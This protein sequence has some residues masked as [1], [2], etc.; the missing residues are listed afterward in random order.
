MTNNDDFDVS[1][2]DPAIRARALIDRG[3]A[4]AEA[5]ERIAAV[6]SLKEAEKVAADAG[7]TS[8]AI[9][10]HINRGWALWY[11]GETGGAI[12]LYSEGA[13][14]AREASDI[15]HLRVALSN[16]GVA[17]ST[18]GR[19]AEAVAVYEEYLPYV[20][21]DAAES[22]DAHLNTGSALVGLGRPDEAIAH[23]E[24][25]ER[26]ATAANLREPLVIVHLNRGVLLERS[27]DT[28]GAFDLYWK[29]FDIAEEAKDADLV[30]RVTMTLGRAY[31]R[32]GD[33]THA[34]DCFGEAANAFR[35]LEDSVRLADALHRHGLA[36]RRVG[37][38]DAA[39]EAW[40]EE[41]PILRERGDELALGECI[42]L[43]AQVLGALTPSP[44]T[45][46]TFSEAASHY[47]SAKAIDRLAE[48]Y[49]AH[50]QWLRDRRMDDEAASRLKKAF[51]ALEAVPNPTVECRARGLNA[52]VLADSG[53]FEAAASELDA[54]EA[55]AT[56][57]GD[58]PG[59]TGVRA[60]R[61]YVLAREGKPAADVIAQLEAALEHAQ[62]LA[63]PEI[64][65]QA[66]DLVIA[67]IDT[68]C[69]GGYGE[70]LLAWRTPPQADSS[71]SAE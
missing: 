44:A 68:R 28:D 60:R 32:V 10:A 46:L 22:A 56:S 48:V 54:A 40:Q 8:I 17:Y 26:L 33:D 7:L 66:V 12:T 13:Q 1:N 43:Q 15:E 20:V 39:V 31:L 11:A 53:A 27:G 18:M 4:Q 41:E 51:E 55:V 35:Y 71:A 67:E 16:L 42:F 14:M 23:F 57:N 5:G 38:G 45:D 50:A 52:L 2:P 59:M 9:G 3:I 21:D 61:A 25:A 19:H 34:C 70:A 64:R 30:G 47:N 24:E 69:G 58:E 49:H 6:A 29:A 62:T 36:L 63:G 37:L 65:E